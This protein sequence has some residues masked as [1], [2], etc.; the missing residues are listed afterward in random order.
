METVDFVLSHYTVTEMDNL[1]RAMFYEGMETRFLSRPAEFVQYMHELNRY[2][3]GRIY[4]IMNRQWTRVFVC[5]SQFC[6]I[7]SVIQRF[8]SIFMP[9]LHRVYE[10]LYNV[11]FEMY[12]YQA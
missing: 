2:W 5:I 3:R 6:V 4:W 11:P 10:Q 1:K 7:V 12:A 9:H 8:F